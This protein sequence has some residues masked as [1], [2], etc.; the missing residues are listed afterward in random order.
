M[1]LHDLLD[2]RAWVGAALMLAAAVAI[3]L[4]LAFL[5]ELLT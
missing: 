5:E 3:M 1:R 4:L 2:W